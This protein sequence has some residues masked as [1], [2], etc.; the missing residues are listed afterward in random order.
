V[1]ISSSSRLKAAA[2]RRTSRDP[3][4]A[5]CDGVFRKAHALGSQFVEKGCLDELR[6]RGRQGI[7]ADIVGIQDE[8]IQG[9]MRGLVIVLFFLVGSIRCLLDAAGLVASGDYVERSKQRC[10]EHRAL[11]HGKDHGQEQGPHQ[12]SRRFAFHCVVFFVGTSCAFIVFAATC[13]N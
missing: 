5:R 13:P 6:P 11:V 8:H 7:V 4:D 10:L 2:R 12:I 9:A 3:T 1:R